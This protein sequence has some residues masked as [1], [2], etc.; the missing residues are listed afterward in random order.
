MLFICFNPWI[1]KW[2]ESLATKGGMTQEMLIGQWF[3]PLNPLNKNKFFILSM[4][5]TIL[6]SAT[7]AKSFIHQMQFKNSSVPIFIV[8]NGIETIYWFN[9]N[10]LT[11]QN[12]DDNQF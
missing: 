3:V 6:M 10:L 1:K 11:E 7:I 4:V 12:E 2:T 5:Y 9:E 8:H